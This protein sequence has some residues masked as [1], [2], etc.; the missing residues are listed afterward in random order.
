[1][2]NSKRTHRTLRK[3]F[4]LFVLIVL[5]YLIHVC[6]TP[7]VRVFDVSP[8]F[9]FVVTAIVIIA[10][11]KLRAF[12]VGCIYGILMETMLPSVRYLNLALYPLIT[13]FVSFVFADK[14]QQRLAYERSL[15]KESKSTHPLGRTVGCA[16]VLSMVYEIINIV[17]IVIGGTAL[18]TLHIRRGLIAIL[19]TTLLTMLVMIPARRLIFGYWDRLSVR[20]RPRKLRSVI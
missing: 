4:S 8:N 19:L 13:L 6:I 7:Y 11:G 5:G 2:E 10:Y 14:S 9:L 3:Y 16:A 17:Y 15:K 12:W 18:Q 1:M 20:K